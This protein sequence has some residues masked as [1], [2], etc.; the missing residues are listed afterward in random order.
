MI[1]YNVTLDLTLVIARLKEFRLGEFNSLCPTVF[2]E[3]GNPDDACY[4]TMCRFSDII[5]KQKETATTALLLKD[6][7]HDIRITKVRPK[8]A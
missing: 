2:T 4:F 7:L 3:A 5:L 8:D 1:I 6:V